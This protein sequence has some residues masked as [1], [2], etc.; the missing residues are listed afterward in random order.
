MM[1][2]VPMT[3]QPVPRPRWNDYQVVRRAAMNHPS[4]LLQ[5]KMHRHSA[6]D[7]QPASQSI[8][9][10]ISQ[11]GGQRGG[12]GFSTD[13][14]AAARY[15]QLAEKWKAFQKHKAP[16]K[17]ELREIILLLNIFVI[18]FCFPSLFQCVTGTV[19]Y[20][21]GGVICGHLGCRRIRS[22]FFFPSFY[23]WSRNSVDEREP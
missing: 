15:R 18:F 19:G 1:S 13:F 21:L 14:L 22:V 8:C 10:L 17:L 16:S 20:S 2:D 6:A 9:Q 3:R 7:I 4:S 12:S 23:Y 5:K 11:S